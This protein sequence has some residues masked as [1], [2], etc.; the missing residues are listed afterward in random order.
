MLEVLEV[1]EGLLKVDARCRGLADVRGEAK[2]CEGS[3]CCGD[4]DP[5]F[6]SCLRI[7]RLAGMAELG[8]FVSVPEVRGVDSARSCR[9]VDER[10]L[11]RR[12][13]SM[14]SSQG[15]ERTCSN[16]VLLVVGLRGLTISKLTPLSVIMWFKSACLS[17][18]CDCASSLGWLKSRSI[19]PESPA[20]DDMSIS[21]DSWVREL[22]YLLEKFRALP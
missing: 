12:M 17:G 11:W 14:S 22:L 13:V 8:G 21:A 18:V 7:V 15:R 10:K 19:V 3:L 6:S 16:V 2:P 1:P 4:A 9:R 5:R 20:E